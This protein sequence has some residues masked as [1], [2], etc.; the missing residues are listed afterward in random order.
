MDRTR[1]YGW[2]DPVELAMAARTTDG[3]E[4]SRRLASG[5]QGPT[6][7]F[8]TLGYAL[9][10]VEHGRAVYVGEPGE[11][12]YNPIGFV[13]GGFAATMLE[14]AAGSAV[15][16][17]APASTGYTTLDLSVH[18]LRPI[19]G[20]TGPVRAIGTLVNRGRRTALAHVELRD[21]ADRLLA[22]A[23]SSCMLFPPDD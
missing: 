21:P 8:A 14:S 6:P 15:H 13:H 11:H 20:D 7:I 12:V 9:T 22:H 18:Y 23:T 16:S 3:L 19:T 5:E 10:E 2:A 1:T 4:F 17:T